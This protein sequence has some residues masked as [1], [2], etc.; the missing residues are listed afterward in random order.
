MNTGLIAAVGSAPSLLGGCDKSQNQSEELVG[1]QRCNWKGWFMPSNS[2]V[3]HWMDGH[4]LITIRIEP[5]ENY[6]LSGWAKIGNAYIIT[7][8]FGRYVAVHN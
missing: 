4:D 1:L 7:I 5:R 8:L 6:F 2:A 3:G